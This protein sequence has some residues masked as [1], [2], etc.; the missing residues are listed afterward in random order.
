[1]ADENCEYGAAA[2]A[3][4]EAM[5][6][7][8]TS[9]WGLSPT[10]EIELLNISENATYRLSDLTQNR[11]FALR[12]HRVGYHTEPEIRSELAW[13]DAL[14][15]DGVVETPPPSP[16]ID[17]DIVQTLHS[18]RGYPAR[19]AVAFEF[20]SGREPDQDADLVT[21]FGRL[22][23]ITGSMHLHSRAWS[24][25]NS[26]VRK[27]WDFD[28]MIGGRPYWG[29]WTEGLGL[30]EAGRAHLGRAVELIRRRMERFGQGPDRFGLIH[31]DLRLANLLVDGE[32]L[33]IID[34]DDCGFSWYLYDFAAAVSFFEH[35][36]IVPA[37]LDAW[38]EGYRMTAPLDSVDLAEM[39][40]FIM[41]RRILL[42]A[43]VASHAETPTAQAM[44]TRFTDQS[45]VMAEELLTRFG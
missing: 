14:R 1:M 35:E 17:G 18:T 41:A 37:L 32:R 38:V 5:V 3:E 20:R 22:G 23:R 45:L 25:P 27:T 8:G 28:A 11:V 7:D 10:T 30:D 9:R 15:S 24:R 42:V 12:L 29:R 16:G 2:L 13:I 40:V 34:F 36:P 6:R 4:L 33:N 19:S 43:W 31:A 39:P 21:W 44:G 26:F